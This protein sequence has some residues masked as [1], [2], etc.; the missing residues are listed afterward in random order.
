MQME[1][2]AQRASERF[3]AAPDMIK[4]KERQI[5]TGLGWFSIGLGAAELLFP[6]QMASLVGSRRHSTLIRFFGLREIGAGVGILTS[7]NRAPWLWA[8]VAG[9]ALDLFSLGVALSSPNNGRTAFAISNVAAV[10]ALDFMCAQQ[11]SRQRQEHPTRARIRQSIAIDRS[12]EDL[13]NFWKNFENLPRFMR[14]L[15][16][17][18]RR[19]DRGFHWVARNP[20][21]GNIE[22]DAEIVSDVPNSSIEWRSTSG[23][24]ENAGSVRFVPAPQ[25]RGTFV[26]VDMQFTPPV[27]MLGKMAKLIPEQQIRQDLRR[28][29]MLMETGEIA[30]IEG[31]PSGR[32]GAK[33]RALQERSI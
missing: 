5:A 11:L 9:D 4:G 23:D 18:E 16:R 1:E 32:R 15:E 26:K 30:T 12:P 24:I 6:R 20:L 17:V 3:S 25:G 8:R 27:A 14:N 2:L 33:I 13:Y 19:G 7:R 10:T 28:F 29:K 31:Q 21:G 22:W